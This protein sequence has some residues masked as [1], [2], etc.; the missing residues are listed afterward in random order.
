MI[1][2][3]RL[4]NNSTLKTYS[5]ALHVHVCSLTIAKLVIRGVVAC[6]TLPS[7]ALVHV[8]TVLSDCVRA[9]WLGVFVDALHWVVWAGGW[10]L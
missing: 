1:K 10:Q 4:S 2:H 8:R 9:A 3:Q 5:K 7:T 6:L